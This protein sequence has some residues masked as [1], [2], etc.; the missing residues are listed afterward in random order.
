MNA[1]LDAE[2]RTLKGMGATGHAQPG[3]AALSTI[4]AD[5]ATDQEAS[6]LRAYRNHGKC[7]AALSE[8]WVKGSV[9]KQLY[10]QHLQSLGPWHP[11]RWANDSA[12][13]DGIIAELYFFLPES[14][15]EL[16]QH[17]ALFKTTVCGQRL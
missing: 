14:C 5:G 10:P 4:S 3:S 13:E 9:L 15:H 8:L 11:E 16:I 12:W 1:Q 6:H 2:L 7:F 17:S